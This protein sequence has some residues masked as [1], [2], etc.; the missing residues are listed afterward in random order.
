ME[1]SP[2]GT[3]SPGLQIVLITACA[4]TLGVVAGGILV[5]LQQ[6]Q[7]GTDDTKRR[8]RSALLSSRSN[9]S[10]NPVPLFDSVQ[11]ILHSCNN[12]VR[13]RQGDHA[14]MYGQLLQRLSASK[15][16][17][18]LLLQG[19]LQ[20]QPSGSPGA[21]QLVATQR[22]QRSATLSGRPPSVPECDESEYGGAHSAVAGSA[23]VNS[24]WQCT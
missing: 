20:S 8:Q 12:V 16:L 5:Y 2:G 23:D 21:S 11:A 15:D 9:S 14:N 17:L 24:P 1:R 7:S 10:S 19:W 18:L 6:R 13:P 4:A 22:S 3:L